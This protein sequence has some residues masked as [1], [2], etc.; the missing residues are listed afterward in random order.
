MRQIVASLVSAVI[1]LGLASVVR[2]DRADDDLHRMQ[3]TRGLV[4]VIG[5]PGD[6]V[7]YLV[8]LCRANELKVYF[9]TSDPAQAD[10]VRQVAEVA[11]G[12]CS[13]LFV[14]T[15]STRRIHLSDN[16]AD[17][18][19]VH[20]SQRDVVSRDE[21]LRVLRPRGIAMMDSETIVK[22][23]PEGADDWSH[24]YHG[25]DNNPQS[26]DS[27]VRGRLRTQ[28]IGYPKFSPMPE[29]TVIAGGRIYKAMGHIAHKANQ[30]EM[31]NTLLCINAFNG[32]I[33]WRR[34]AFT[35]IH[36][37]S[38]YDGRHRRCPLPRRS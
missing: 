2:G 18:I 25:P 3:L 10:A 11:D 35:R 8:D 19:L 34:D 22:P 26:N 20:T 30:N 5:L 4:V 27:L 16:L 17:R 23:I 13:R 24:P 31:L 7:H 37:A 12:L 28:F 14:Q 15:G 32:T 33:L 38:Q 9:Q 1:T 29:Q 6:D 21:L 36:V